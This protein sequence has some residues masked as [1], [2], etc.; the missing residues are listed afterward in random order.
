LLK[1]I[2]N[3]VCGLGI[4]VFALPVG[5]TMADLTS[6]DFRAHGDGLITVDASTGLEWL[7]LT[8]TFGNSIFD[9]EADGSIYDGLGTGPRFRWATESDILV[10]FEHVIGLPLLTWHDYF[11]SQTQAVDAR[12]F[13]ALFHDQPDNSFLSSRG[14]MRTG[15]HGGN[16]LS[17][18][19][20]GV[21]VHMSPIGCPDV[22]YDC[23]GEVNTPMNR[24]PGG[25][26]EMYHPYSGS[27]LVRDARSVPEPA[28]LSLL[29]LGLLGLGLRRNLK[30]A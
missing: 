15:P 21:R 10:L 29:G 28:T 12:A 1:I 2:K 14:V 8:A 24:V 17:V 4:L 9:T 20:A 3:L 18:R 13:S 11:L 19:V 16:S 25:P 22:D 23:Y 27:W 6:A 26:V 30:L 5:A 7:D